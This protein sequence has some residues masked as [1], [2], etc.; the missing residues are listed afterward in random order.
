[1]ANPERGSIEFCEQ[2]FATP[3]S[4]TPEDISRQLSRAKIAFDLLHKSLVVDGR[5]DVE[6]QY[7]QTESAPCTL[8]LQK[9]A[10]TGVRRIISALNKDLEDSGI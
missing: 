4:R 6:I 7:A 3:S 9:P 10:L 2:L 5:R 8:T 1:M